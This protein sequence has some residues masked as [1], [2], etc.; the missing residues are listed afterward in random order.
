MKQHPVEHGDRPREVRHLEG[1]QKVGGVRGR[2]VGPGRRL[3]EHLGDAGQR[4]EELHH[5]EEEVG[6]ARRAVDLPHDG[7]KVGGELVHHAD[8]HDVAYFVLWVEQVQ[9]VQVEE[10]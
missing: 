1:V 6:E 5:G 8:C 4:G 10:G 9:G 3:D 7:G 2:D